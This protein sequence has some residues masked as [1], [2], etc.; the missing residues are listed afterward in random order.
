MKKLILI[1]ISVAGISSCS[2]I[3]DDAEYAPDIKLGAKVKTVDCYSTYGDCSFDVVSNCEYKASIVKGAE[4][5]SF[6]DQEGATTLTLKGNSTLFL[7]YTANRGYRR[8]A[9]VV[10]SSGERNDTL[11]VKQIG[12]F[13]QHLISDTQ[14]IDVPGEGGKYS[15][16]IS[17][18][19]LKKDL[20]FETLDSKGYQLSGKADKY[21]YADGLF[22]FIILPSESRDEKTFFVRIYALDDW[23][24]KVS[25]SITITQQPGRE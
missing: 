7:S 5:L 8:S 22:S 4:W 14:K 21:K 25:A 9:K 17:T 6:T 10:L 19:L 24:E 3:L 23:G 20:K 16:G 15:V 18:N 1:L 12:A 2:A 11:T 13:D